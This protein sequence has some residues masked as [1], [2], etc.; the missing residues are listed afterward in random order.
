M[1]ERSSIVAALEQAGLPVFEPVVAFQQH[2][3][4]ITYQVRDRAGGK[5]HQM[6]LG[7]F[8]PKIVGFTPDGHHY[9]FA[10][11]THSIAQMGFYLGEEGT[12]Y[13]DERFPS[14]VVIA[15]SVEKY[16]ESDAMV[17]KLIDLHFKWWLPLGEVAQDD[18]RLREQLDLPII[19]QASDAYTTWWGNDHIRVV[20]EAFWSGGPPQNRRV[21]YA[22]TRSD[23]QQFNDS[24]RNLLAPHPFY[25]W[26]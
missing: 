24:L 12:M 16:L 13:V 23:A 20:Q 19:V 2:F 21:C 7:L 4:G 17:D 25:P 5:S 18:S 10:C 26:P 15:S 9:Y 6:S 1:M 11:G 8:Q 3:G 14:P 22:R